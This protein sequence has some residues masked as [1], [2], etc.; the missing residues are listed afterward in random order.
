M[1]DFGPPSQKKTP[2]AGPGD[3]YG[4]DARAA[5]GAIWLDRGSLGEGSRTHYSPAK[6]E[7]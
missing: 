6:Q 1:K 2:D 4:E 3:R 5:V 7:E